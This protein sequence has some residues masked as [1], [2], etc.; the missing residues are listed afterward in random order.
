MT[1]KKIQYGIFNI[2]VRSER[3]Y[4]DVHVLN[5]VIQ[6]D[7]YSLA[8]LGFIPDTIIDIGAHIGSFSLYAN[9]LFPNAEIFCV[10]PELDNYQ[11]LKMNCPF[12]TCYRFAVGEKYKMS[13]VY[14]ATEQTGSN[15]VGTLDGHTNITRLGYH[16]EE[17]GSVVVVPIRQ[18]TEN[19]KGK[20]MLLKLDCEGAEY[21]ILET[22]R[23]EDAERVR[24]IIGEYHKTFKELRQDSFPHLT[25]TDKGKSLFCAK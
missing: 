17:K 20:N 19:I 18:I 9:Q 4:Q 3:E 1:P 5:E 13:K 6:N 25:F 11:L 14:Q 8:S 2:H 24:G 23:E 12:A 15:I 16:Y 21:T 22:I 10:E 7:C